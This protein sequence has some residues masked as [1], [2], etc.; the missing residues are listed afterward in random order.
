MSN[1]PGDLSAD[2]AGETLPHEVTAVY[3]TSAIGSGPDS[4]RQASV[5]IKQTPQQHPQQ[6]TAGAL[7][8][9]DRLDPTSS[10]SEMDKDDAH[11]DEEADESYVG[12]IKLR[13]LSGAEVEQ[14]PG[15]KRDNW[16]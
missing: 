6:V 15:L 4:A 3:S 13:D 9:H 7:P 10:S 1:L 16:W 14:F 2:S 12:G 5:M 11:S 8:V